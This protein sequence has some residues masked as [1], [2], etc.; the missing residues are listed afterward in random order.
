MRWGDLNAPTAKGGL[1]E[2]RAALDGSEQMAPQH[3]GT[4]RKGL[5]L[6]AALSTPAARSLIRRGATHTAVTNM[7]AREFDRALG[8]DEVDGADGRQTHP[9]DSDSLSGAN[10]DRLFAEQFNHMREGRDPAA[11][12][13]AWT[14]ERGDPDS[15]SAGKL[16]K[17][18]VGAS[19]HVNK[20]RRLGANLAARGNLVDDISFEID[21]AFMKLKE[22]DLLGVDTDQAPSSTAASAGASFFLRF[23]IREALYLPKMSE[24]E[25]YDDTYCSCSLQ[26][27]KRVLVGPKGHCRCETKC[28]W[29]SR[30]PI[31]DQEFL[32]VFSPKELD[33]H[34]VN[35]VVEIFDV[36]LGKHG[37]DNKIG[38]VYLTVFRDGIIWM[39]A[40]VECDETYKVVNEEGLPV[41]CN[42]GVVRAEKLGRPTVIRIR[43]FLSSRPELH[44]AVCAILIQQNARCMLARRKL[45]REKSAVMSLKAGCH[46]EAVVGA[47]QINKLWSEYLE[48]CEVQSTTAVRE[49]RGQLGSGILKLHCYAV[50]FA[51][52]CAIGQ[53]C[54][55]LLNIN[56]L[57]CLS[58][59]SAGLRSRSLAIL[60]QLISPKSSLNML[61]LDQ[62]PISSQCSAE[63]S[64]S[65]SSKEQSGVLLLANFV[66]M[67]ASLNLLSLSQTELSGKDISDIVSAAAKNTAL[68]ALNLEKN[69]EVHPSQSLNRANAI[70]EMLKIRK[71]LT[72]FNYNKTMLNS[73]GA[74]VILHSCM[75]SSIR[76]LHLNSTGFGNSDKTLRALSAF[77]ECQDCNIDYLDIG[78]CKI[79]KVGALY[80][81][82]S[83]QKNMSLR[84]LILDGNPL[85]EL[86]Y[87][88]LFPKHG[89]TKVLLDWARLG[90]S[91]DQYESNSQLNLRSNIQSI[92]ET[93]IK[94]KCNRP[95]QIYAAANLQDWI[96]QYSLPD[97]HSLL[98]QLYQDLK[99]G[100]TSAENFQIFYDW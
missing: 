54:K 91:A 4:V 74:H 64:A 58:L 47:L 87:F 28:V 77:L 30:D 71:D 49:L 57:Y 67:A 11:A 20:P 13:R 89:K 92:F 84:I 21:T 50:T 27:N 68:R 76:R 61:I 82:E 37:M 62:N 5:Q 63:I 46:V 15:K 72:D 51:G 75:S 19:S 96:Q 29:N 88:Y 12:K 98:G 53:L 79:G 14:P 40:E 94:C 25:S 97:E 95:G 48:A 52:V 24:K 32:F 16:G 42:N 81:S 66:S 86:G 8:G 69:M 93:F 73:Q 90:E 22:K 36:N 7:M 26:S 9:R 45:G 85:H 99:S 65:T 78:N 59:M 31:W 2:L 70:S 6:C 23:S 38:Q 83:V 41:R 39:P 10:A 80:L 3:L 35:L 44:P 60:I 34:D 100:N 56:E 18:E 33:G 43:T 1:R 55:S 17:A